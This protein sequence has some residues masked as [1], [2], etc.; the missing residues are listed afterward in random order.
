MAAYIISMT[1]AGVSDP[2]R[3]NLKKF[4]FGVGLIF[5]IDSGITCNCSVQV[6]GD[7]VDKGIG[8]GTS[9]QGPFPDVGPRHW[10][11]HDTLQNMTASQN[12][13]LRFPC[14]A[15]RILVNSLSGSVT[16]NGVLTGVS[17]AVVHAEG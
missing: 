8:S 14:T 9:G 10:A 6:T 3:I 5:I 16:S 1:A 17:L 11:L 15:V 4:H 2:I 13:S 12:S 7:P